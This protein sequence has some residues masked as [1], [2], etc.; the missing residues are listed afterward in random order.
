MKSKNDK[1]KEKDS[2]FPNSPWVYIILLFIVVSFASAGILY[3][4]LRSPGIV[5]RDSSDIVRY[6]EPS[7]IIDEPVLPEEEIT[8]PIDVIETPPSITEEHVEKPKTPLVTFVADVLEQGQSRVYQL[9]E[10]EYELDIVSVDSDTVKFNID[11]YKFE[12]K[13]GETRKIGNIVVGLMEIL[14][15]EAGE[16]SSDQVQFNI[17]KVD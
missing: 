15:E 6:Q 2:H 13:M 3:S 1:G 16:V 8:E 9:G 10:T 5:I 14:I 17:T 7:V 11:D 4:M 12:L